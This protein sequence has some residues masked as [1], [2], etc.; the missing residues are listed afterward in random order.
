MIPPVRMLTQ[1]RSADTA[2]WLASDP[3][4][5]PV[6]LHWGA[7]L[8]PLD[9]STARA[10]GLAALP[11]IPTNI[12]DD[13]TPVHLL[14]QPALGYAGRAGLAGVRAGGMAEPLVT[15]E[16]VEVADRVAA[17]DRAE[18]GG[19]V[20][21]HARDDRAG[22]TLVS[23]LEMQPSGVVLLRH[24]VTNVGAQPFELRSLPAVLPVPARGTEILD[25][26]GRWGRERSPQR[27]PLPHGAW[28]RE[29]RRGRTGHDAPT[30]LAAVTPGAGQRHGEAWVVHVAWSGWTEA[31]AERLPE[32]WTGIGGGELL[33]AGELVLDPGQTYVA[34]WL[35]AAWSGTGLD[36]LAA[37]F[38]TAVRARDGHPAT[39]RP[40]ILNTWEAVWFDHDVDRLRR[41]AD[42]AAE[43]GVERF[44]LDDG[45]FGARRDD[46]AG[47]GDWHVAADVWPDGLGPL[48]DHVRAL[49]LQFGLWVEPE[50]VNLDSD[51]ARAHPD[52]LLAPPG[53]TPPAA[54]RQH[55]LD[56]ARP[57][58]YAHLLERL[59]A[60]L[61]EYDIGYLKWDHNRDLVDAVHDGRPGVHAQTAALYRLLDE[62]RNRHPEVEIESCA[63]GGGRVDLGVLA[64]TD[65]IWTS[66]MTDALERQEIQRWTGLL[67][68]PELLGAHV[69]APRNHQT[70]RVLD[71]SFRAGTALPCSFGIE[72]D[73]SAAT[74]A[75][76][77]ELAA[78]VA[79]YKRL[80]PLLHSGISVRADDAGD[81]AA[82]YGVVA[83]DGR[84]ALF[85]YVRLSTATAAVPPPL[86]LPGLDPGRDYHVA[87]LVPGAAPVT[88]GERA[89]PWLDAGGITLRSALLAGTGLA[90]PLLAPQQLLLLHV[91]TA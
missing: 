61:S 1:L 64:R 29:Q 89:P 50:M 23:E 87:P 34:P 88:T 11:A 70:G 76:R 55:T 46:S 22:L 65:R 38:H 77:A 54:R 51:L 37:R 44:V 3:G 72:W 62:V 32:G 67:L 66:D 52:W 43:V 6:V 90:A 80:R 75:E 39:P 16:R 19:R 12:L 25:V 8:G 17:G 31:F 86:R 59:D 14:P 33:A 21:V 47:L 42:L 71:L 81:G 20:V 60:L 91:T 15:V 83:Q 58:V 82:L 45:W 4:G 49:G 10:A 73:I 18:T 48:V 5:L 26:S 27:H 9:A 30:V 28:V 56:L 79:L 2:L 41:L 57:D 24:A 69:S 40:V 78:W 13:P 53:R 63:S 7:D 68:P 74:P 36:G 35:W 85:S 84:E